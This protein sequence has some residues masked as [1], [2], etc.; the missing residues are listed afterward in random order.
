MAH[1]FD[2]IT[3]RPHA[4][5]QT[6]DLYMLSQHFRRMYLYAPVIIQ[7]PFKPYNM[8]FGTVGHIAVKALHINKYIEHSV[9][10]LP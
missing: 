5:M 6:I 4:H 10:K 7:T 3:F 9:Q 8:T 2:P 1:S